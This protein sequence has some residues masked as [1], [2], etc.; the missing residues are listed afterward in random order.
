MLH[1]DEG[2]DGYKHQKMASKPAEA[3][4]DTESI[5]QLSKGNNPADTLISDL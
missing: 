3:G 5:S 4:K 1:D 2:R